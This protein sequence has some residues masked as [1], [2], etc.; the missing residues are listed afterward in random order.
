MDHKDKYIGQLLDNRYEIIEK[1]GEGG[2]SVVYKALCHRLNRYVA[3]K[4]LKDELALDEDFLRRFH[5]ESQAVAMLSHPNIVTVYDVSRSSDTEYIVM[6]L[7]EGITLKQYM[8]RRGA[9]TWKEVLHFSTQISKALAHAHSRGIIHRDI[10]PHNIL[11]LADSSVKVTDFGIARLTNLQNTLTNETLGSVHYISPEQAKGGNIDA[12]TDIYSLGVVMYE[13]LTGRLPFEGDSAVSIA[14]QHISSMPLQPREINSDVPVGLESITMRAMNP[15]LSGR[16]QSAEILHEDLENFRKNP[17]TNFDYSEREII[18]TVNPADV[19]S[20]AD[21]QESGRYKKNRQPISRRGELSKEEYVDNRRR[22]RRVSTLS[23]VFCVVVF[24]IAVFVFL[25]NYWLND[26]FTSPETMTVPELTG[27][28]LEDVLINPTYTDYY[29]IIPSYETSDTVESGY[30]MAQVP[31]AGRTVIKN[32]E[33]KADLKVV[34]SSGDFYV[35]MPEVVNS[36]YRQAHI[37]LQKLK[38]EVEVTT[39]SSDEVTKGYVIS[40]VPAAGVE[41]KAGDKVYLTVS[42]GPEIKY[43]LMPDLVGE[44]VEVAKGIIE[45]SNLILG[46]VSSVDDEAPEGQVIFQNIIAGTEIAENTKVNISISNGS[47]APQ[48]PGEEE[49]WADPEIPG[50]STTEPENGAEAPDIG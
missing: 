10:K 21:G 38:L 42:G 9:L 46:T 41:L 4:V 49:E 12:R 2:M 26:V 35:I 31:A 28:R 6:E 16:Y 47:R 24:I 34:V 15:E 40:S 22:A 29:N 25:W 45:T 44:S 36:E 23:G 37:T 7:I 8:Q 27:G 43:L 20:E 33:R 1:I 50:E 3:V 18:E 48:S 17:E 13:M 19:K 32:S 11:I 30:I 5:T 39:V 14:I